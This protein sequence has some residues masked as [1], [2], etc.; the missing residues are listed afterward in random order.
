MDQSA[1][2]VGDDEISTKFYVNLVS[3]KNTCLVYMYS[4]MN[5]NINW[6][7]LIFFTS[8]EI[9]WDLDWDPIILQPFRIQILCDNAMLS[10]NCEHLRNYNTSKKCY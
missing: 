1:N 3:W 6:V 2:S 8:C 9:F 4:S 10:M 7:S 5:L